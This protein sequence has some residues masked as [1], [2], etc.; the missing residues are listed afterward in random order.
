VNERI[1]LLAV[2]TDKKL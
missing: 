1:D 2:K